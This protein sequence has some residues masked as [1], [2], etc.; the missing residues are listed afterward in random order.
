M[1]FGADEED[2]G[3]RGSRFRP[4]NKKHIKFTG[5]EKRM[6][7]FYIPILWLNYFR[8][9]LNI[10]I[11]VLDQYILLPTVLLDHRILKQ[12]NVFLPWTY[13]TLHW[14]EIILQSYPHANELMS[15][16]HTLKCWFARIIVIGWRM[17]LCYS[18]LMF[19]A[20]L[21]QVSA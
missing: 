10:G 6:F 5:K 12:L 18:I 8:W 3:P 15:K 9:A 7:L 2:N 11:Y 13:N 4:R 19:L 1:P 20:Q 16:E 17:W 14:I 21:C